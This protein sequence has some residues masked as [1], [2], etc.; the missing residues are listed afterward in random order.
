MFF[1][2]L[3]VTGC[4]WNMAGKNDFPMSYWEWKIIIPTQ[5][6]S[7]IF[8]RGRSTSNQSGMSMLILMVIDS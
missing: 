7:M 6:L 5:E 2:W 4:D 1:C 3:V 8:Q